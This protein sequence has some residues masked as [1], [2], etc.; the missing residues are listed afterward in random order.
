VARCGVGVTA[1][2]T[3]LARAVESRRP[4]RL[5]EDPFAEDFVAVAGQV[6]PSS[7]IGWA[8]WRTSRRRRDWRASLGQSIAVRTRFYDDWALS[9]SAAGCRQ[10]ALLGAGLDTRAFRL[11]WPQEPRLFELDLPDM[12]AFKQRVL[13][14]RG[15]VPACRRVPVPVDL[16]DDWPAALAEAG[17]R[18]GQPTAWLAEG[19]LVYLAQADNDRLLDRIG[20]LSAPGSRL[21]LGHMSQE[22][23]SALSA[24]REAPGDQ[25]GGRLTALWR[26]GLA[27]DPAAWLDRHGWRARIHDPDELAARYGRPPAASAAGAPERPARWLITAERR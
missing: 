17:H 8:G 12:L 20:R 19:L 1:V 2:G 26:S 13:D 16:R 14:R 22:A 15:A 11:A 5:F 24:R 7:A 25:V 10:V 18:A 4:D 9:A 21:A 3:A 23:V 27:E 6:L